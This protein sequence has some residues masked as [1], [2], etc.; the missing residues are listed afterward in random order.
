MP[1]QSGI[2]YDQSGVTYDQLGVTYDSGAYGLYYPELEY[3]AVD[4]KS[5]Q[6][7][8]FNIASWGASRQ[9]PPLFRGENIM[10]P[11]R[12]GTVHI[13]KTVDSRTL[14]LGMWVLGAEKDG[15]KPVSLSRRRKFETNW[16]ELRRLLWTPNRQMEVQKTFYDDVSANLV[17]ASALGQFAGGLSPE[18]TGSQRAV[19]TVDIL[20]ADPYF[21]SLYSEDYTFGTTQVLPQKGDATTLKTI[22]RFYGP[23]SNPRLTNGTTGVWVQ[24]AGTLANDTQYVELDVENFTAQRNT[25]PAT[26]SVNVIGNVTHFGQYYWMPLGPAPQI[27]S[28]TGGGTVNVKYRPAWL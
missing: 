15:S 26:P 27:L 20:L 5:L 21:Y 9:A 24:W 11:H 23:C 6:T 19:F 17:S 12:P 13:P 4:G 1:S 10:V 3:W 16:R 18:M 14:T 22:I 28:L 2:T 7:Y 25:L 8:A